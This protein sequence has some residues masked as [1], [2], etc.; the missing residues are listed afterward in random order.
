MEVLDIILN[1]LSSGLPCCLLALGIFLT[2]RILDFADLTAEGSFLLGACT[3]G[4]MIFNGV[5]PFLATLA[6]IG[7][8][9]ICGTITGVLNRYLKIPKLLSGIITLTASASIALLIMGMASGNAG[10]FK[11]QISFNVEK[12][13]ASQT[14]YSLFTPYVYDEAFGIWR[15]LSPWGEIIKIAIMAAVVALAML[16]IYF[17]FGTEYGM[18]IRATGMS[19]KMA[20]AQGINTDVATIICVAISNAI[21]ALAG[22]LYVQEAKSASAI[23]ATGYLVIGLAS[24]IVG[25]A[26]FGKRSFKNWIISVSLGS[27]LYF[28]IV[29]IA[30]RLG[31]P[32]EFKSL[33]YAILITIALCIP[34]IKNGVNSIHLARKR[35]S[36]IN[37]LSEK[38]DTKDVGTQ[39]CK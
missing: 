16:A 30:I 18:A 23:T 38:G 11:S 25:E 7:V 21:I 39:E 29:T 4:V 32:T 27:I 33:L 22:A 14:I 34:F 6:S 1:I 24:I 20:K 5:N 37:K 10:L 2:Y 17:F 36:E 31:L 8:G 12:G 28:I 9:A 13:G 26:V 15:V 3:A 19:E 35:K